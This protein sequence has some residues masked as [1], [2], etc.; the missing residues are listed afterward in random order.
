[1]NNFV[2]FGDQLI[3]YGAVQKQDKKGQEN[4][5]RDPP[6]EVK[7]AIGSLGFIDKEIY[8]QHFPKSKDNLSFDLSQSKIKFRNLKDNVFVITPKLNFDSHTDFKKNLKIYKKLQRSIEGANSKD[9][10][11]LEVI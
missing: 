11:D 2:K 8:F 1:M 10:K 6:E 7:G 5:G 4:N 3:F 9:R